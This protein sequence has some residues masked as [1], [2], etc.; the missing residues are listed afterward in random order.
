MKQSDDFIDG[1]F[2]SMLESD[3]YKSEYERFYDI[4]TLKMLVDKLDIQNYLDGLVLDSDTYNTYYKDVVKTFD[5]P[6]HRRVKRVLQHQQTFN[7]INDTQYYY[8]DRDLI[9]ECIYDNE[10]YFLSQYEKEMV[11]NFVRFFFDKYDFEKMFRRD[12]TKE[13]YIKYFGDTIKEY[14]PSHHKKV[15]KHYKDFE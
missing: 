15:M 12:I 13:E 2:E 14:N 3:Y 7:Q 8:M 6:L 10:D 1:I 4:H 11:V 9:L 5:K